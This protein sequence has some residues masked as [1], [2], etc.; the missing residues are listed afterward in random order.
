MTTTTDKNLGLCLVTG[1]AGYTGSHLVKVLLAQGYCVRALVRSTPLDLEHENL[2]RFNGDIQG[3]AL[4]VVYLTSDHL[5]GVGTGAFTRTK[6]TT[7]LTIGLFNH[8]EHL[9][10]VQIGILNY[11]ANNPRGLKL[12]PGINAHF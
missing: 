4:S 5:S 12:L 9:R 3:A 8:T 1:S 10:G 6:A 7:G 2:E 11:A